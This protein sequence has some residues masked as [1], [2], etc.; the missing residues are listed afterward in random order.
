MHKIQCSEI[1]GGIRNLDQDVASPGLT[2]SVFSSASEGG[3]G[4]DIYYLS[5]CGIDRLTRVAVADVVGHGEAVT[6][7]SDW[8]YRSLEG[9][10]DDSDGAAVLSELN[11]LAVDRGISALTTAAILGYDSVERQGAFAY[12]GHHAMLIHRKGRP[13]W[14]SAVATETEAENAPLGVDPDGAY[15]QT[16]IPLEPGDRIFCYT[17]GLIEARPDGGEI[18][19]EERL[20][21]LLDDLADEPLAELKKATLE[22]VRQH[23]GGTLA[24]DDVTVMAIEV[25]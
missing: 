15:R 7:V 5:V 2:A 25:S 12:A 8:M 9:R 21:A 10:M 23:A 1:W 14:Q 4:G 24:H 6:E 22:A 3:K 20:H 16:T 13:G 17:D 18:F 19:G 11:D